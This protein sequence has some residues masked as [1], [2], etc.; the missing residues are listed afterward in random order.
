MSA[1]L[2]SSRFIQIYDSLPPESQRKLVKANLEYI[3][4]SA[5][6]R[7]ARR[8]IGNWHS[9]I[10]LLDLRGK[11]KE[12]NGLLA[13]LAR[14]AKCSFVKDRSNRDELLTEIIDSISAWLSTIWLVIYEHQVH[15][16]E[17]HQCLLFISH[18]LE[19]LDDGSRVGGCQCSINTYEVDI[20]IKRTNGR[21]VKHFLFH[22]PHKISLVLLWMW[23]ELFV[24]LS[25]SGGHRARAQLLPEML[26][27]IEEEMGWKSLARLLYGGRK[28]DEDEENEEWEDYNSDNDEDDKSDYVPD[29]DGVQCSCHLHAHHWSAKI[30]RQRLY[31]RAYV[32]ERLQSIFEIGPSRDLFTT[33]EALG[34]DDPI[35]TRKNLFDILS[36]VAGYSSDTLAAALEI[37]ATENETL[38]V[39]NLLDSHSSLL[40]PRDTQFL[41]LA[42]LMLSKS[43]SFRTR[44]LQMIEKEI[45]DL[46]G[47]VHSA[48]RSNFCRIEVSVHRDELQRIL[49]LPSSSPQRS[50]RLEQWVDDVITPSSAPLHAV[51]FAAMIV[52]IPAP[53]IEEGEDPDF[54]GHLDLDP[55]DPDLEDLRQELRPPLGERSPGAI[56]GGASRRNSCPFLRAHDV[57]EAMQ[58]RISDRPSK[59][60]VSD[61][62]STLSSFA[63][64]QRKKMA[65]RADKKRQKQQQEQQPASSTQSFQLSAGRFAFNFSPSPAAPPGH[66]SFGGI[67]DLD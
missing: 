19:K 13:D 42:L 38:A 14:D 52:G 34:V 44:A 40:R 55:S 57:A 29:T 66:A 32:Q 33:L 4:D 27:D 6:K 64:I 7:K 11:K 31:L 50:D 67:D 49:K 62:L 1:T 51:A 63:K 9:L 15:F 46:L 25:A 58:A 5:P 3:L 22:G 53:G 18:V 39:L 20:C 56:K 24:T 26:L 8:G 60:H 28:E 41:Q 45:I 16:R 17:A 35:E 47:A 48:I 43:P 23:R 21:T 12:I 54:L 37:Y 10:P 59:R 2:P 65:L 30:D 36:Q 61:A